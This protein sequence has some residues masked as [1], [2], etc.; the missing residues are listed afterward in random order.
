MHFKKLEI[1][2]F[3]SFADKTKL[4]FKPAVSSIVGPNGVGKSN[5]AE[6]IRWVLGEQSARNLRSSKME[7]V[8]FN[9]TG[10]REPLSIAEVSLTLS[11]TEKI[12]PLDYEEIA[13]KRKIFRSGENE[14][15]INKTPCRLKDI[16][17]LFLNTGMSNNGYSLIDQRNIGSIISSQPEGKR[18]IFEQVSGVG[19]YRQK[20]KDTLKKLTQTEA[21]LVRVSDIVDE[22]QEQMRILNRDADK[23]RQYQRKLEKLKKLELNLFTFQYNQFRKEEALFVQKIKGLNEQKEELSRK[24]EEVVRKNKEQ[25]KELSSLEKDLTAVYEKKLNL[26]R[27]IER[28]SNQLLFSQQQI[29]EIEK[30]SRKIN[31]DIKPAKGKIFQLEENIKKKNILL[32]EISGIKEAKRKEKKKREI[33]LKEVLEKLNQQEKRLSEYRKELFSKEEISR[34]LENFRLSL[35]KILKEIDEKNEQLNSIRDF[36]LLKENMSKA[37]SELK[38]RIQEISLSLLKQ[39]EIDDLFVSVQKSIL[40]WKEKKGILS[41]AVSNLETELHSLEEKERMEQEMLEMLKKSLKEEREMERKK[42]KEIEKL[43]VRRQMLNKQIKELEKKGKDFLLQKGEI[44]KKITVL[45]NKRH[46]LNKVINSE[47]KE[48]ELKKRLFSLGEDLQNLKIKQQEVDLEIRNICQRTKEK[49]KIDVKELTIH[50]IDCQ[51]AE[52]EIEKL[53]KKLEILGDVSL[54][55]IDEE[56]RLDERLS[57]LLKQKEDLEEAKSCIQ[58]AIIKLDKQ[59]KEMFVQTLEEVEKEFSHFFNLLFLGG[60]AKIKR[61]GDILNSDIK[62]I[63]HP[64]GKRLQDV[65]L[66]SAGERALTAIALLFA[67]FKIK[68]APFCVLDEVDASLDDSNVDRFV[69]ILKDF[70]PRTQFIIITHNKKTISIADVIYGVTMEEKGVSK[71]VSVDLSKEDDNGKD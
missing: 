36:N 57:F 12:L 52:E 35:D 61:E 66:L 37:F 38:N 13:V 47:R 1:F 25:S 2:G 23:A 17:S 10:T 24:L 56:K 27:L 15:F 3:K 64:P 4:H 28:S 30:E 46:V 34:E 59:A 69:N 31:I 32:D 39:K 58:R 33:S 14:Y 29:R 40:S 5:I 49:Y 45:K 11:N 50:E 7:D 48:G 63:V 19:L 6:A 16:S 9:G 70:L 51:K 42:E 8:I 67:L 20:K 60:E 21:N 55:T 71:L 22:L 43:E 68:P 65:L 44:E 41:I 53:N 18:A 54:S 62:I 26:E